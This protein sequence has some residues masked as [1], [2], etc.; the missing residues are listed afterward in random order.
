MKMEKVK[1]IQA[2]GAAPSTSAADSSNI[3]K[4]EHES[5]SCA[6]APVTDSHYATKAEKSDL[7][8]SRPAPARTGLC[9][10]F[11]LLAEVENPKEYS[12]PIKWFITFVISMAAIAAPLGSTLIFRKRITQVVPVISI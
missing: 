9:G 3:E 5:R 7:E 12:R 10:R 8:A 11:T 4:D 6:P 1:N 2:H